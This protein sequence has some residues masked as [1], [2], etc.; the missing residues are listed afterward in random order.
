MNHLLH[1]K[2][3]SEKQHFVS[4]PIVSK[5]FKN[6]TF[7]NQPK[8]FILNYPTESKMKDTFL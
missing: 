2:D 3:I 4:Y 1:S 5:E 8:I 6:I 7:S